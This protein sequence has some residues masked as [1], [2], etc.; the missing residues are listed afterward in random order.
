MAHFP[1]LVAL[2]VAL[3]PVA[4]VAECLNPGPFTF[5]QVASPAPGYLFCVA[6][7]TLEDHNQCAYTA[8]GTG[9]PQGACPT[10]AGVI[11]GPNGETTTFFDVFNATCRYKYTDGGGVQRTITRNWYNESRTGACRFEEPPACSSDDGWLINAI[12]TNE[13]AAIADW[14]NACYNNC[15]VTATSV[16]D[17]WLNSALEPGQKWGV[18]RL[19]NTGATCSDTEPPTETPGPTEPEPVPDVEPENCITSAAGVEYC[20]APNYGENCGYVNDKFVCLG[21][22]DN[23]ECW[24]NDDGSRFCGESA[25]MPPRPDSGVAGTPAPPN[26][27]VQHT[28]SGGVTNN[29]YYYNPA[30]VAGSARAPGT[31]GANPNNPAS[32]DPRTESSP[33][34]EQGGGGTGEGGGGTA[35]GGASCDAAPTCSGD[36]IACAILA[37]QW[38]TRCV[39]ITAADAL[40]AMGATE[41]E[42]A[43]DLGVAQIDVGEIDADGGFAAS[44][45]PTPIS[46]SIM[47]QTL[48]LDVWQRGCDMALLFAPFV[49]AM[50]YFAGAMLFIRGGV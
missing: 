20:D 18:L 27:T 37:Q 23:D 22:T 7:G 44:A 46:V 12:G 14:D 38:R 32:T 16:N 26:D 49:L 45:C 39:D 48:S 13:A 5:V 40:E 35:S 50:G 42:I 4:S 1:R 6:N 17:H 19:Q 3:L 10:A 33:V 25:P 43:G 30:T 28:N 11:T 36:P 15:R 31:S 41:A 29:Y 9:N 8:A 2:A 47:G 34:T 21:K 24:I